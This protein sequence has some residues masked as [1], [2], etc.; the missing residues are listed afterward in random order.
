MFVKN[1]R[2]PPV[3]ERNSRV[4]LTWLI[5]W[6]YKIYCEI[7]IFY[8][9]V[10]KYYPFWAIYVEYTILKLCTDGNY[11]GAVN[12]SES[13]TFS[14]KNSIQIPTHECNLSTRRGLSR[15]TFRKTYV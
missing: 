14:M 11:S 4:T 10:K 7:S 13:Q 2:V 5:A 15:V 6:K 3:D 8:D 1:S 9:N 12:K